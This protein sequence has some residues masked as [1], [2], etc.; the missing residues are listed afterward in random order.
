[1]KVFSVS[2]ASGK[3]RAASGE[4]RAASGASS[5][6]TSCPFFSGSSRILPFFGD[7]M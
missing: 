3:R 4:R 2:A 6:L 1:M 7:N 5:V